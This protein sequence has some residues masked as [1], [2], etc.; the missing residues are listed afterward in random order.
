MN[1]GTKTIPAAFILVTSL[2][3][4]SP[5]P[6]Q[7]SLTLP[8]TGTAGSGSTAVDFEFR[9]DGS[10]VE[11]G[12]GT[13]S[14]SNADLQSSSR[15]I[16]YPALSALCVGSG[17]GTE[18]TSSVGSYSVA[19]GYQSLSSGFGTIALGFEANSSGSTSVALGTATASG[20]FSVAV[21]SFSSTT[22]SD[23][24]AIGNYS[25]A[26]ASNAVAVS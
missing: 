1:I 11:K 25:S 13:S 8:T 4:I 21:G 18:T 16:W 26:S 9:L 23:S 24:L 14:L 22:A 10:I 7:T 6:A 5:L 15:F 2:A 3:C 20:G 17:S 12:S 19:M